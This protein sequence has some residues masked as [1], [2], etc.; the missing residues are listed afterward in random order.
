MFKSMR[1]KNFKAYKDSSEVPLAPLTII[2][3]ANNSGKSTLFHALLALV[4][5]T[6]DSDHGWAPRLV[7]KRL[8]DLGGFQDIVHRV[9][10]ANQTS[11]EIAVKIDSTYARSKTLTGGG[12]KNGIRFEVPDGAAISFGLDDEISGISVIRSTLRRG[13]TTNGYAGR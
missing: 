11:F 12:M 5:T 13:P 6:Q 1:L 9:G 8:V 2:V 10:H 7:T 4:Q 3:G